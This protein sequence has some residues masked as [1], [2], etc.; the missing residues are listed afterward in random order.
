[1]QG[2]RLVG[3]TKF[4][5]VSFGNYYNSLLFLSICNFLLRFINFVDCAVMTRFGFFFAYCGINHFTALY[6]ILMFY[7]ILFT[8]FIS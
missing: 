3:N 1:M 6:D 4:N 5:N 8:F 7:S 2:P